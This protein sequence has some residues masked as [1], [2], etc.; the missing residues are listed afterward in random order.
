M[1]PSK[2]APLSL[3]AFL[4]LAALALVAGA[5]Y[6]LPALEE[7]P[8]H[9]D[10]AI[11]GYKFAQFQTTGHF[12]YD[13]KDYHGPALHYVTRA[14]SRVAMWGGPETWTEA[15][16]RTVTAVCGLLLLVVTLLLTDALGRGGVIG[17]ML[18][19]AVSPMEV[20]YSRYF[21]MEILLVLLVTLSLAGFWRYSQGGAR[22]WLVLA[23]AAI[24][25]QHA[26]KET[27]ILN[28]VAA[29]AAWGVARLVVGG[30]EPRRGGFSMGPAKK[31]AGMPWLW[32]AVPAVFVSVWFFSGGFHD[33]EAVKNSALTYLSYLERSGGSGHEKPWHYY[34]TL[35]VWRRNEGILWTEAFIMALA[36][37]GMAHAWM[38]NHT[39][40]QPRQA[41]L[42][43]LSTYSL[44]LLGGYSIL[45]YKTPWSIL[46]AQHALVLLAGYGTSVI[47][48]ATRRGLLR[49]GFRIAFGLGLYHLCFQT[50]LAIHAYCADTR[51][52]YVYS[53]TVQAFPRVLHQV[54]E[55]QSLT[56]EQ[57]LS[58]LVVN[59]DAG[60]PLLWY[61]RMNRNAQYALG[62]P[63]AEISAAV[64]LVDQEQLPAM[65]QR[66]AGKN[67]HDNGFYG[68]RPN[69]SL[70]MLVEP[71]LWER[72]SAAKKEAAVTP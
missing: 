27:F 67:Y 17:A 11:L 60:W 2:T 7:R 25:M 15:Q 34:L 53:H 50:N 55:L 70:V 48:G 46:S 68:L 23:G 72:F 14:W 18:L 37:V 47:A 29:L 20:F 44:L 30:F 63:E 16:L 69:N 19:L 36:L 54:A 31:R 52:P 1:P 33:W 43:F 21:I 12:Q 57:P 40:N 49:T 66:L 9:T 65:Q 22:W 41:F 26:T 58:I 39:K 45:S 32:V 51:N 24:G 13:P 59:K 71:S 42:V 3:T 56:P 8:M 6:R 62:V 4:L 10:E 28:A 5:F 61:W 64:I 38:G 35:L